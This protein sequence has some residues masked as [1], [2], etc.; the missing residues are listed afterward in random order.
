ME[1][2]RTELIDCFHSLQIS[3]RSNSALYHAIHE[4]RQKYFCKLGISI[5]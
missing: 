4:V 2:P 3:D 5:I 1:L